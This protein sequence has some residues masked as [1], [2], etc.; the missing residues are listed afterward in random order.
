MIFVKL[1]AERSRG[2]L[3]LTLAF[4]ACCTQ[5]CNRKGGSLVGYTTPVLQDRSFDLNADGNPDFTFHYSSG[6][7][8]SIPPDMWDDLDL[9]CLDSNEVQ[10]SDSRIAPALIKGALISDSSGWS[11]YS[12]ALA[13][14]SPAGGQ[15]SGQFAGTIPHYLGLRL[16]HGG[17][18]NYGWVELT[19]D[20]TGSLTTFGSAYNSIADAPIRAGDHP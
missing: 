14:S 4:I 1:F 9:Q 12:G 17:H 15:W 3:M 6:T 20:S 2:L 13:A 5:S 10:T 18:Y 19:V 8:T 11:P 7:T 16:F